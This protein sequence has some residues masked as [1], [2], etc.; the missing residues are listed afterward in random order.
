MIDF[1]AGIEIARCEP[2][3]PRR[4]SL[5]L[6]S[7]SAN[8]GLLCFFKYT[9]FAIGEVESLLQW[10][11]V[12]A[13]LPGLHLIL[14][15]GI[16]FYTFQSMSY[17]IDVYRGHLQ[18]LR[19]FWKF[20]LF[21]SFF[22]QLVAGPIV[23][24]SEF[25][26]Q[27]DRRR[28]LV[29]RTFTQ[30]AFLILRGLFLKMVCADNI[31]RFVDVHWTDCYESTADSTVMLLSSVLFAAQ[32]FCD[33][34]GYSSIARG[35]AYLLGFRFPVNFNNPYLATSFSNFW[36]RWHITLSSWLRDYLYVSLGGNRGS[37]VRTYFN[38]MA[39]MVLGGLWHGAA[40]TFVAW[41][42]LH[43]TA[44]AIERALGLN[45]LDRETS[46]R[47]IRVGWYVVVQLVV[48]LTWI[49]FRSMSLEE[50]GLVI[51]RI[52]ACRF[53]VPGGDVI[54]PLICAVPMVIMHLRGYAVA[55]G[56]CPDCGPREKAL[57]AGFMLVALLAGY[58]Q[59]TDFMYFQF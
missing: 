17:T 30:G 58:G 48:L 25:I 33:F 54:W 5:L 57:L 1:Y 10:S 18:P 14:P 8:L 2:Q 22:P 34:A 19:S 44:L 47:A 45:R 52:A 50:A 59:S 15:M 32:I 38:L 36:Q 24:A 26:Y 43:G 23:R 4:K 12:Q 31:G 42:A 39:V 20:A 11:G 21:V 49:L 37:R 3:S 28:R 27:L 9:N 16:S 7:L 41:G 46:R 40:M 53:G 29:L 55:R 13:Q 35:L 56:W 51:A 6:A